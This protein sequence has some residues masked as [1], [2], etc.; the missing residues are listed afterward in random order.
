MRVAAALSEHPLPTHAVGEAAGEVLER[1]GAKADLACVF[2]TAG[3]AGALEDIGNA[4]RSIL[5]P[6]LLLGAGATSIIGGHREVEESPGVVVF[7]ARTGGIEPVRIETT[8]GEDGW[9]VEGLPGRAAQGE[10]TLLLLADPHTFPTEGFLSRLAT[11]APDLTVVGGLVAGAKGP[12]GTRLSLDGRQYTDGA[13]G[14]LFGGHA[15]V[16]PVLAQGCRPVGSPFVVTRAEHNVLYELGGRPALERLREVVE[17][18]GPEERARAAGGLQIGIVFDESLAT[19]GTGDF[20][21]RNVLGADPSTGG[22]GVGDVVEVGRTVQFH[23]RDASSADLALRDALG[24]IEGDGALVF[25]CIGRGRGLFGYPDHDAD[26]VATSLATKA[27]AGVFSDGEVGPV[28]DRN[29][30]HAFSTSMLV[31]GPRHV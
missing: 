15:E 22:V 11:S 26:V 4:V 19:F 18:L 13:V 10:R 21:I 25:T 9:T 8:R 31:F 2:V 3:H 30:L 5:R 1:L 24:E 6:R 28:G 27:T 23:V 29:L 17:E 12:G 20:L 14:I 16:V 7:A